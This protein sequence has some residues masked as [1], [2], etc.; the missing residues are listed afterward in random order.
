MSFFKILNKLLISILYISF[1][2]F[3]IYTIYLINSKEP[4]NK[5]TRR[6]LKSVFTKG[7]ISQ[8]IF[9]DYREEFLPSTQFINLN[10]EKIDLNFLKLNSCYFG[11]CYTFFLEQYQDNLIITD[12]YG[13]FRYAKFEE[14]KESIKNLNIIKTNLNFDTILDTFIVDDT[15]YVSGKKIINDTDTEL[16]VAKASFN[17]SELNFQNIVELKSKQCFFRHAVHSGKIQS[18][19]DNKNQIILSVN[20][21]ADNEGLEN[22]SSDSVC[23]KI[24]L[25]DVESGEYEIF[26]SGHRNI[27][28]MYSDENVILATEH[29]PFAG[30]EI[31]NI[32]QGLSYGWPVSSY[33]EKYSRGQSNEPPNYKKSHEAYGFQ[34]PIFSFIPAI[35]ISEIIRLPNKFSEMWQNNFLVASL[36][37]KYLYRIKFDKD[38]K[39]IIYHEKI[40]I[41][42]RIRDIIYN[43]SSNEIY[44]SLELDGELG[45]IS[46]AR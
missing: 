12:R 24:L 13:V 4:R 27:I 41:G 6:I 19:K 22:L 11:E 26:T 23:G 32:Q 15:I 43:D 8:H 3:I 21:S 37:G 39:K 28:G 2:L 40:F 25:I 1:F 16:H 17:Y 14:I 45:I 36:N 5:D 10:F 7:T 20:S 46:K 33:G 18:N 29:G 38:Y 44:L 34:E 35:G 31:N 42:D 9:N 30:D